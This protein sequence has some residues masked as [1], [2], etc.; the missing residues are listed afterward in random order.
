VRGVAAG[1]LG[2]LGIKDNRPLLQ[3][4]LRDPSLHVRASAAEALLRLGDTSAIL[5][6]ADLARHPDPSIRGAAAQA[7]SGATDKQA[8]SVLQTLLQ[9]QQPMPRLM[10]AKALGK[11]PAGALPLLLKGLQDT[12]EAVRIAA[13]G[14][15]IQQLTGK[16][17]GKRRP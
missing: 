11:Q 2:R 4:L 1:S 9:D 6:I 8:L 3:P 14:S 7:L 16:A 10:A 15:V 12:D 17:A 13:A 5:L